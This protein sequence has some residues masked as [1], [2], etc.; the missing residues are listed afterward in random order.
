MLRRLAT[1]F[2]LP[3]ICFIMYTTLSEATTVQCSFEDAEK[4]LNV[5]FDDYVAKSEL[6]FK[7][8][9]TIKVTLFEEKVF[10][11]NGVDNAFFNWLL[12]V[13]ELHM[14][15]LI[16]Q[17]KYT[18]L[19]VAN[20]VIRGDC[21]GPSLR[22]INNEELKYVIFSADLLKNFAGYPEKSI[23]LRGNKILEQKHLDKLK[24]HE[25]VVDL[26][27]YGECAVPKPFSTFA[28]LDVNCKSLY[29][30]LVPDSSITQIL[31]SN[32]LGRKFNYE[33][34]LQIQ[35]TS[36]TD[37]GFLEA[38][39]KFKPIAFCRQYIRTNNDL[40]VKNMDFIHEIFGDVEVHSNKKECDEDCIGG[41]VTRR[42]L[43][44]NPNCK[45]V[46]GDL[47]IIGWIEKP[48]NVEKLRNIQS[49]GGRL[50][51]ENNTDLF[52]F[53]YFSNLR[54]VNEKGDGVAIIIKNN[55]DLTSLR[56]PLLKNIKTLENNPRVVLINNPKWIKKKTTKKVTTNK[57]R[58]T[59]TRRGATSAI[60][61]VVD[62]N[63]T[64]V[65]GGDL[66]RFVENKK[67]YVIVGVAIAVLIL[68]ALLLLLLLLVIK[69]KSKPLLPPPPYKLSKQS[70]EVLAS[71][72]KDIVSNNPMVWCVHDQPLL[73]LAPLDDAKISQINI[74]KQQL[75]PLAANASLPLKK[76]CDYDKPLQRRV[77]QLL[78]YDYVV[79]I[80]STSDIGKVIPRLPS[81]IGQLSLYIDGRSDMS[82]AYKL[83]GMTYM[84]A[85]IIFYK[86]EARNVRKR[87]QKN[88]N[89]LFYQWERKRL[90]TEFS[91]LLQLLRLCYNKKVLCVSDRRKEVFSMLYMMYL[92]VSYLK[93]LSPI[94]EYFQ[95]HLQACNGAPLD[96]HEMLYVMRFM[97]DWGQQASCIPS[98]LTKKQTTWCHVYTQMSSFSQAHPSIMNI[99]P[100]HLPG[101]HGFLEEELNAVSA[102]VVRYVPERTRTVAHDPYRMPTEEEKQR[103]ALV[104]AEG[105]DDDSCDYSREKSQ[106]QKQPRPV[107]GSP[108]ASQNRS[109]Q[110]Q[111][112]SKMAPS[113]QNQDSSNKGVSI[114]QQA[115]RSEDVSVTVRKQ[116][117]QSQDSNDRL[118]TQKQ[119]SPKTAKG[120][121]SKPARN[122][123][124]SSQSQ[125][126]SNERLSAQ[127]QESPK[128][129]KKSPAAVSPSPRKS[130][131]Y[132]GYRQKTLSAQ[133]QGTRQDQNVNNSEYV[134]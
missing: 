95:L 76:E 53:N 132:K 24:A 60:N 82:V 75:L 41:F 121:K 123:G 92:Q 66:L 128:K 59:S 77:Q 47:K 62:Q 78:E 28:T 102:P 87:S 46:H 49:I 70:K 40:C 1:F 34:C 118:L 111:E 99:C 73:W 27:E 37:V 79:M 85:N 63:G 130:L 74:L 96:R 14:C 8:R 10:N 109:V 36:L 93:T 80:G 22:I 30:P 98:H 52:G 94:A 56:L 91:E 113:A 4:N 29:G 33:G 54:S 15:I 112:I 61:K 88:V 16:H 107:A 38:I 21:T 127:K 69:I 83:L 20:K 55:K 48:L 89:V 31:L 84:S 90:P 86:Y 58:L 122:R 133:G 106:K 45:H 9:G 72:C 43:N 50:I 97:L 18:T 129:I 104:T 42:Y 68:L 23:V 81:V 131:F 39:K 7:C 32:S 120:K 3:V 115:S 26:Q 65:V 44:Q 116:P 119:A 64:Y 5:T 57:N 108:A 101:D 114:R 12:S 103:V 19:R 17:T 125:D 67:L 71:I 13:D 110:I 6:R 2:S 11:S 25:N 35:N 126:L 117:S 124:I 134:V 105:F 51:I 100:Q